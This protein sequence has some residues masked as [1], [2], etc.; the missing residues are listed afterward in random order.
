MRTREDIYIKV[1]AVRHLLYHLVL[2]VTQKTCTQSIEFKI[3]FPC[4]RSFRLALLLF[5]HSRLVALQFSICRDFCYF[6]SPEPHHSIAAGLLELNLSIYV[7]CKNAKIVVVAGCKGYK[8][9]QQPLKS[10]SHYPRAENG[11]FPSIKAPPVRLSSSPP[12]CL[13]ISVSSY[14]L[15]FHLYLSLTLFYTFLALMT[16][17]NA[18]WID[19]L[20]FADY[21]NV[22]LC[23]SAGAKKLWFPYSFCVQ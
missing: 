16:S 18:E 19:F 11:I 21:H 6:F 5:L 9:R 2:L 17:R 13:G 23:L 15:D 3:W 20:P 14:F 1:T 8:C 4:S 22:Y 7:E 10:R 12:H